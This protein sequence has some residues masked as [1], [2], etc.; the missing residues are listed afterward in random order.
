MARIR[1]VLTE[2]EQVVEADRVVRDSLTYVAE[3]REAGRWVQ[4]MRL[5]RTAVVHVLRR[6]PA[7]SSCWVDEDVRTAA[8]LGA[9]E[10]PGDGRAFPCP[11]EP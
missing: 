11:G 5:P 10:R 3:R 2:G 9:I 4:V 6:L 8:G 1:F 7:E